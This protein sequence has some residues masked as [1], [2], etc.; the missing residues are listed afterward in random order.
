MSCTKGIY[1]KT[2]T[3]NTNSGNLCFFN[4]KEEEGSGWP[5][6][7][8]VTYTT[9]TNSTAPTGASASP[10]PVCSGSSVT[11][12]K[13]GGSLG[14]GA[15][16][17]WYSGSCGGTPVGSGSSIT[18]YPTSTTTYYV[19]AEG[20]CNTTSCASVT[21]MVENIPPVPTNL[22][23][24]WS[25]SG[26][27]YQVNITWTYV[28][29]DEDNFYLYRY[30]NLDCSGS[31][32]IITVSQ[33][34]TSYQE[35][36]S[37]GHYS[38]KITANNNLCGESYY[39]ENCADV[40]VSIDEIILSNSIKISPNPTKDKLNIK[41]T[42][43]TLKIEKLSVFNTLGEMLYTKEENDL[44]RDIIEIDLSNYEAGI[45]FV[46]IQAE[47]GVMRKEFAVVR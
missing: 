29:N 27:S 17:E 32:N 47:D 31:P 42:D 10:N 15:S 16:W 5:P 3:S 9:G 25:G 13:S 28:S 38:Y 34:Q 30:N 22:E 40:G 39:S 12:I 1:I 4:S 11:L 21:V 19:R 26:P 20:D 37:E 14:T 2:D 6:F 23:A 35:N 43:N 7:L 33:N 18:V 36:L 44:N 41:F 8:E 46:Y 45:Y 24:N